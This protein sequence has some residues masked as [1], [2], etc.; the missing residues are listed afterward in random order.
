M[1]GNDPIADIRSARIMRTSMIVPQRSIRPKRNLDD[2]PLGGMKNSV[3]VLVTRPK[4]KPTFADDCDY[5]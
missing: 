3:K 5:R 4:F 1:A 2:R